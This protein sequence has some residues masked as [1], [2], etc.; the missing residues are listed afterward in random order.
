[1][2]ESKAEIV[3]RLEKICALET[4]F[5]GYLGNPQSMGAFIASLRRAP[6]RPRRR[7]RGA[8]KPAR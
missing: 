1:M 5:P 2:K 8:T 7:K 3:K 6:S 4:D